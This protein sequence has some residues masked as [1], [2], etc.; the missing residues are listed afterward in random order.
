VIDD[1]DDGDNLFAGNGLAGAWFPYGDGSGSQLPGNFWL[2]DPGGRTEEGH[3]AHIVGGGFVEWGSGNGI[4][5]ANS[6][7]GQL[8]LFDASMYDGI[9]FW[10]RGHVSL[11]H[12][13]DPS[14]QP[15]AKYANVLRV[16]VVERDVV[17]EDLGGVC[18]GSCW[19]S[20]RLS[21]SLGECWQRYA[22]PFSELQ[23]DGF[24]AVAGELNLDELFQLVFEVSHYQD[25]DFWIDDIEFYV[26]TPPDEEIDCSHQGQGGA[27][28][29]VYE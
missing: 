3:A 12:P 20:H 4:V 26:G 13:D 2:P 29:A 17:P 15:A 6:T 21:I 22:I 23:Q 24:G 11:T 10:A 18:K 19:D 28:G 16:Q 7:S 14:K 25:F 5:F 1:F 27:G 9:T 8:C